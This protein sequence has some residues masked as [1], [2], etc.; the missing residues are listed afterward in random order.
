M[1]LEIKNKVK[2][3]IKDN[4]FEE[5]N[6]D[7]NDRNIGIYMIY[8][9]NFEDD[10][11]IPIYIGQTGAGKDRNF[12][13]RFKEHLQE[14]MALNRLKYDYYKELLLSGFYDGHY[15]ACKVFKYMVDHNCTLK[16]FHMIVLEKIDNSLKMDQIQSL[17]DKREQFF[18]EEY[19]PAFF[20]FNQL[21][22]LV[23]ANKEFFKLGGSIDSL[24]N[25]LPSDLLLKYDIEDCENF[26]KY[27]GYGYTKFNYYHSFSKEPI[28]SEDDSRLTLEYVNKK[29]QLK[30]KYFNENRF[31]AYSE[32]IPELE[33][34]IK[35]INKRQE[36]SRNKF[37]EYY[38]PQIE[39]YC[40]EHKISLIH[41]FDSIVSTIIFQDKSDIDTY[42][43][44]LKN[45]K[46]KENLLNIFNQDK[47]FVSWRKEYMDC[48]YERIDL[49]KELKECRSIRRIDDL[50]RL[51]PQKYDVLPLKDRYKEIV[52]D[53]INNGELRIN[54][55]FSNNGINDNWW[56]FDY[57]IIKIDYIIK[58]NNKII[59]KKN[60]FIRSPQ[61]EDASIIDNNYFEKNKEVRQSFKAE[62]F[63]VRRIGDYISTTMELKNGI[64]DYTLL[65]KRMHN[66]NEILDEINTLIT[67]YTNVK[68][69]VK[70]RMKS[71][72]RE[73]IND[74]YK[75]NNILK[76]K[77]IDELKK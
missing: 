18:F 1:F 54:I 68:V 40:V 74:Y 19:L 11:I 16:D 41:K 30:E 34:N 66:L 23:E 64:N 63:C 49:S 20:G 50:M 61:S 9:D 39:R 37:D 15:K 60:I 32:K 8:I 72:C 42:E 48:I 29:R 3:I 14:I 13:K 45:K 21:N 76:E 33:E 52:F 10:K 75:A 58:N 53:T 36:E 59:E 5:V 69:Q 31:N 44:Y 51:L 22:S 71:K 2:K 7:T 6:E 17:L 4:N 12:Q 43:K 26:I 35:K 57:S 47:D 77:I 55:E 62:P 27:F 25:F 24:K 28:I 73:Y 65:N 46:I 70:D 38:K 56:Y 67:P